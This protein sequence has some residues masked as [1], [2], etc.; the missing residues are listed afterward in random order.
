MSQ[1][2]KWTDT[3]QEWKEFQISILH[4]NYH[5]AFYVKVMQKP[6]KN[7]NPELSSDKLY[8]GYKK[9]SFSDK[10]WFATNHGVSQYNLRLRGINI[11]ERY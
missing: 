3:A 8:S 10:F 9:K 7:R 5:D 2:R 4:P 1:P 6:F 11:K